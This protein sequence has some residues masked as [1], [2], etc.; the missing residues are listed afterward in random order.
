MKLPQQTG[1]RSVRLQQTTDPWQPRRFPRFGQGQ[2]RRNIPAT[3]AKGPE[4]G[5]VRGPGLGRSQSQ[6]VS[7][8]RELSPEQEERSRLTV[9]WERG[10]RRL[11]PRFENQR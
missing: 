11:T 6:V 1:V 5:V 3:R 9:E 2:R 10:K 7:Q 4:A 8:Q